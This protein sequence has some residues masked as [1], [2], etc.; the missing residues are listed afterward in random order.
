MDEVGA[1][2]AARLGEDAR[3]FGVDGAAARF[4]GLGLV[5]GGVGGAVDHDV[6]A[7]L[8]ETGGDGLGGCNVDVGDVE[9]AQLVRGEGELA[10][11]PELAVAAGDEDSGHG[12]GPQSD[13]RMSAIIASIR[14]PYSTYIA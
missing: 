14:R 7:E 6:G 9:R 8:G 4:V 12:G 3:A 13:L 2:G 11:A 10:V 5:D 1:G